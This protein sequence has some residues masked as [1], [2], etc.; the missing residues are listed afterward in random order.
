M[1]MLNAQREW[2][3][4][5]LRDMPEDGNRYEIIDGELCVS[6]SPIWRH[7]DAVAVLHRLLT[8]Y[9]N[10]ERVGHAFF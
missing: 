9:L 7:Q 3:V 4:D 5:D 8:D 1:H 2:T 10:V 6:P